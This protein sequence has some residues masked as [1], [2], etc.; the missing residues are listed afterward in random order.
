[1]W[2]LLL[3][4]ERL[5]H[6]LFSIEAE[7]N[8]I[9]HRS[10][11]RPCSFDGKCFTLTVSTGIHKAR[12]NSLWGQSG[13]RAF[14]LDMNAETLLGWKISPV[15]LSDNHKPPRPWVWLISNRL[16]S[17]NTAQTNSEEMWSLLLQVFKYSTVQK[18]IFF[19]SKLMGQY[20][21]GEKSELELICFQIYDIAQKC[22]CHW[23]QRDSIVL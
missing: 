9:Q 21:F 4:F 6:T 14:I 2:R 20:Q 13:F 18:F 22:I 19:L 5:H 11:L 12:V 10:I 7:D 23:L 15:M 1:M 16:A 8:W 3:E 17:W